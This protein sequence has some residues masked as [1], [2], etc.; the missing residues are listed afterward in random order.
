MEPTPRKLPH[1]GRDTICL[2]HYSIRAERTYIKRSP[3]QK[4]G[5]QHPVLS[6][7]ALRPRT[8]GTVLD[9]TVQRTGQRPGHFSPAKIC[10]LL[11]YCL[12]LCAVRFSGGQQ[13]TPSASKYASS[14]GVGM[15]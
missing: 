8:K 14:V 15:V 3:K 12:N 7:L 11:R 6:A 2:K 13:G 10:Y 4:A 1:R 5:A 9:R